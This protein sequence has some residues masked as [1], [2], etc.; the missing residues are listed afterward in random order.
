MAVRAVPSAAAEESA[1][2]VMVTL[3]FGLSGLDER[4][5]PARL[6]PPR[7][8]LLADPR[9]S[10]VLPHIVAIAEEFSRALLLVC[11]DP[12]VEAGAPLVKDLWKE[13]Q[14]KAEGAWEQHRNAWRAWFGVDFND[15][16]A[17]QPVRAFSEARNAIMHGLGRLTRRQLSD[18]GGRAIAELCQ[19]VGI[20]VRGGRIQVGEASVREC[21]QRCKE[22]ILWLDEVAGPSNPLVPGQ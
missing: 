21:A 14:K 22:F 1:G 10:L 5:I 2:R 8:Q 13:G 4:S 20:R 9:Y 3:A 16:V 15:C 11:S 6:M 17:W 18:D 12:L 19:Q 7:S